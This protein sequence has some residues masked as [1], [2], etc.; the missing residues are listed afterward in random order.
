MR[1]STLLYKSKRNFSET[2]WTFKL[3]ETPKNYESFFGQKF[4]FRVG[5]TF[6]L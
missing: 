1:I 5:Q 6:D 4:V 2:F 3:S